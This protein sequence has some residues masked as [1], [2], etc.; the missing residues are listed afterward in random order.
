[1]TGD[2]RRKR[3]PVRAGHDEEDS[4]GHDGE[5]SL[6]HDGEDSLGQGEE[7]CPGRT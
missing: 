6:G 2:M 5:D 7:K 1:M 3:C 4:L